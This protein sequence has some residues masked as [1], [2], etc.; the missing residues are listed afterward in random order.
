MLS[1]TFYGVKKE[2]Q[3]ILTLRLNLN[4]CM[5]VTLHFNACIFNSMHVYS[6]TV[7]VPA[8]PVVSVSELSPELSLIVTATGKETCASLF[9]II[10]CHLS[11]PIGSKISYLLGCCSTNMALR[12]SSFNKLIA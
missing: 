10:S 2:Y 9:I 6:I 8:L 1:T 12:Y 5:Q 11:R 4:I 3:H 7:L